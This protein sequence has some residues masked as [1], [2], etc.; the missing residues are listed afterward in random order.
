M[1]S[2]SSDD[3]GP[4]GGGEFKG[5]SLDTSSQFGPPAGGFHKPHNGPSNAYLPAIGGSMSFGSPSTEFGN[6][7]FSR[8]GSSSIYSPPESNDPKDGP[9]SFSGFTTGSGNFKDYPRGT[10]DSS[11]SLGFWTSSIVLSSRY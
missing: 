9:G 7:G 1:S 2:D 8:G 3:Q 6:K 11:E 4:S 10:S 5:S